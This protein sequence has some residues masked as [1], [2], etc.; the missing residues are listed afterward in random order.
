V[1]QAPAPAR[2]APDAGTRRVRVPVRS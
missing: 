2:A 1:A